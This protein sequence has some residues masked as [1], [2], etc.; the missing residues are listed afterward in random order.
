MTSR[1]KQ[2]IRLNRFIAM[3]GICSRRKADLLIQQ[4]LIKI[5][6]EVITNLGQRVF[7]NDQVSFQGAKIS[8]EQHKYLLL[9]KPKGY[10]TTTK[11]EQGRLTVMHLI[12][13]AV[14]EK[15][16]PV[17]RL[18]KDTTG[19]LLFTN[20]GLLAKKL[21]HPKYK[22][23]KTYHVI[24]D[25]PLNK[26]T[27]LKIKQGLSLEDGFL[28]VDEI[29]YINNNKKRIQLKIHVG[30]N[31]IVR[32]LFSFLGYQV[33]ELDRPEYAFLNN[34][35]LPLGEWRFLS[36]SELKTLKQDS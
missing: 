4:G 16:L 25:K 27:L 17:G 12:K 5:N 11:D 23:R 18:D 34:H 14:K 31:R 15:L 3:C 10:I 9:N 26:T 24:L 29:H 20:D 30:K 28:Q 7:L 19:L 22:I 1:D 2:G 13:G 21:T 36:L 33:L 32:R 35:N 8:P 6:N